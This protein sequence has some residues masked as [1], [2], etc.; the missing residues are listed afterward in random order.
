[1]CSAAGG[2]YAWCALAAAASREVFMNRKM[3]KEC[4]PDFAQELELLL[5]REDD[6]EL[7]RQVRL[8]EVD[9]DACGSDGDFCSMLC[10]GLS[11]KRG[12]GRGDTSIVLKPDQGN[13]L[14]TM[15]D[16]DTTSVEVFFRRD[17]Q[18]KVEQLRFR[19]FVC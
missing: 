2:L 3:L 19:G 17:I 16:H 13:V 8:M 11:P 1:M 10:T 14:L 5:T 18:E 12:W 9:V 7:A 6:P 4:L 15:L